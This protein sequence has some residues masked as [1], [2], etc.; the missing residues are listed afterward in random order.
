MKVTLIFTSNELN[1]NFQELQFRDE[2]IGHVPPL[3]L[4]YVA[5]MLEK[6]GVEVDVMD[7]DAERLSY[8]DALQ[9]VRDFGP[10][11]IGFTL[12]TYSFKP[13]LSWINQFDRDLDTPIIVGGAHAALYPEETMVHE[14][15]DY[16]LVGEA[17][18]PLPQFIR[19]FQNGKDFS[20][21]KSL[22]YRREDG[23]V[24]IDKTRQAIQEIDTVAFPAL[25][26]IDNTIYSNIISR[27]KNFT[28]ML[29]TRGCPYK[30]TFC[31]QKTP[32]YRTR[33]V[34]NCIDEV[35]R[36]Y[37]E[38]DV[39]EFDIYDST[40]TANKK[41]V[42]EFCN[43]LE[44][45]NLDVGFTIRSRVDSVD[46]E[47]LDALKRGGCHTIFYG[48]ESSNE[49]ILRRMRKEITPEKIRE[50]V[51]YTKSIGIDTL[52]FFMV[53]YPGETLQTMEDT[54]QFA[55]DIPLDYAQFT[56]LTPF[57]DTEIY[58]Y[59]LHNGLENYWSEYT[60]DTSKERSI[61]LIGTEITRQE[62][63]DFVRNAYRRFYFR[64]KIIWAR[65]LQMRSF[66]ELNAARAAA[67]GILKSSLKWGT[68]NSLFAWKKIDSEV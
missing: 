28:A 46:P 10:D 59:Y 14:S 1:P 54:L 7:M 63:S 22:C 34:Q 41:R 25:H 3:S 50:I 55:M 65:A 42:K 53:G 21:I 58:E 47:V 27:R 29:T 2:N 60:K 17:D 31:D 9:R 20:G 33:S 23:T 4:L 67:M 56:V 35:V 48:V 12:S 52:G 24:V 15:I 32:P 36:N 40:F 57:P 8:V 11:L 66:T 39:R 43:E 26:L 49:E 44:K 62:A 68:G 37:H 13:I 61:E 45:L 16:L 30:C 51:T 6:E 38:Y 19:A 64:P 18:L 5:S